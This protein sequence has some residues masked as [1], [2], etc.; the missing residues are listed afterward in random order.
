MASKKLLAL[1]AAVACGS[2]AFSGCSSGQIRP[3]ASVSKPAETS[4]PSTTPSAPTTA[5]VT[6]N[7]TVTAAVSAALL[8]AGAA[9]NSLQSSDYTGLAPGET[10]YAYDATTSTYWAGAALVPSPSSMQAQVS[11]QDDGSYLLFSRPA[12]G[13][14]TAQDVGV[15]GIDG[16]VCPVAVPPAILA[17]W[18]WAPGT[19]RA[20]NS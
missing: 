16:S 12:N 4:A 14:W 7:L 15:T 20:P 3:S 1:V 13:A 10:Y 6:E 9:L 8:Q 18:N 17:L 19:C 11:V 5:P 2:V